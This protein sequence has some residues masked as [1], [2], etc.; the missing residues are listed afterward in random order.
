MR[1]LV[2]VIIVLFAVFTLIRAYADN[3]TEQEAI[4]ETV[5]VEEPVNSATSG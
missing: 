1:K 3:R 5:H 4:R 2:I